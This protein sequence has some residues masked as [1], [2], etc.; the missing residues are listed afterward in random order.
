M[1]RRVVVWILAWVCLGLLVL[2]GGLRVYHGVKR[3]RDRDSLPPIAARALIPSADPEL[4]YEWNPGWSEGEF[5]V[6]EHG[7]ADVSIAVAK[8]SGTFRI[9]FIGDSVTAGFR[10]TPREE[11]YVSVIGSRLEASGRSVR[12]QTLDFAVNGYA[13]SQSARMLETRVGAFAPDLVVAQLCLNDPSPSPSVYT[14]DGPVST[15]L[16]WNLIER[17]MA[18]RR[19]WATRS[20]SRHYDA[21]GIASVRRA[22]ARIAAVRREGAPVLLVLFPYLDARAYSDWGFA[23]HHAVYR[24]GASE[25]GLPLLDLYEPFRDAGLIDGISPDPLHPGPKG[26]ALAAERIISELDRLGYLPK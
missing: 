13:L 7:M 16:L 1:T 25:V 5:T 20:V 8:P 23:S 26:H 18:P 9:A 11:T 14:D 2:E 4:I 21:R 17:R 19:F 24:A 6:N 22:L 15:S 12:V 10:L 3:A